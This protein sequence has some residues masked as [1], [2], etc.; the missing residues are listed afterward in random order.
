M[1]ILTRFSE[2]VET[3]MPHLPMEQHDNVLAMIMVKGC[4]D[5]LIRRGAQYGWT[6][7]QV[8]ELR[9]QLTH[10][11]LAFTSMYKLTRDASGKPLAE[12]EAMET[13]FNQIMEDA[14]KRLMVAIDQ[15]QTLTKRRQGPFVGC[16]HCPTKCTYRMDVTQLLTPQHQE[17][18]H[19]ELT[20]DPQRSERERYGATSRMAASIV[21]SWVGEEPGSSLDKDLHPIVYCALVHSLVRANFNDFEHA[22][23]AT[24][25]KPYFFPDPG[26][27]DDES[28]IE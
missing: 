12:L 6:Y 5:F 24:K 20:R 22:K 23:L 9:V 19:G 4:S 17:W 16:Q 27:E 25:L 2:F 21:Q 3:V 11:M 26:E 14:S 18:L 1:E 7:Q 13:E 28:S 8:E 10:G 15:Y